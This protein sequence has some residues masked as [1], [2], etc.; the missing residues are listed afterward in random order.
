MAKSFSAQ[1]DA[2][3]KKVEGRATTILRESAQRT[4]EDANRP[5]AQGGRMRV[6]TGFLRSSLAASLDGMPS[7]PSRPDEGR[8]DPG[9]VAMTIARA[10]IGDTIFAGWT[11]NYARPREAKDG[12]LEAA[13]QKW[14][15]TV[16]EVT[17]EAKRRIP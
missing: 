1:L 16:R 7:G 9:E 6:D 14:P 12:F 3:A 10:N 4:L 15:R 5:T 17:A 8:G 13:A 11:A 2:W